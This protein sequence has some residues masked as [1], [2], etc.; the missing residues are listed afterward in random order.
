[1]LEGRQ[2]SALR[3]VEADDAL[4]PGAPKALK[5]KP[6]GALRTVEADDALSPGAPKVQ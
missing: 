4:S 2:V 1:M 5:V 3:T 6:I